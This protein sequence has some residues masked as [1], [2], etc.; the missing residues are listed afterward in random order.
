MTVDQLP[1]P[2]REFASYLDALLARLDPRGGWSGVFW[3]RDAE[4][5][6][7]CLDG[8][9]VPPWD[10]VEA[11]L[12]D[13]GVAYGPAA[14]AAERERARALHAAALTA[15][16]AR[17]GARDAL[18]DRLDVMLRE[19]R[20]AAERQA[21]LT[22]LLSAPVSAEEAESLHRDLAW[23]HDDHARATARCTELRTRIEN[24]DR[25]RG[26]WGGAG[27]GG[28]AWGERRTSDGGPAGWR[29]SAGGV[30]GEGG[31]FVGG[32]VPAEGGGFV[33]GG[34]PAD[35]G[36]LVRGHAR[37]EGGGLVG[38]GVPAEGGAF[39][40]GDASVEGARAAG[41]ARAAQGDPAMRGA[42]QGDPAMRGAR[43][44]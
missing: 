40:G 44:G 25:R 5:M 33:G 10:V 34:V 19:Q 17:P 15:Y 24:L 8:R 37:A 13:L 20:Y 30:P 42:A 27:G 16:D 9:E 12:E 38:G 35:G 26:P 3:Q 6:R 43:S 14:A 7:A 32:G 29:T 41:S 39:D 11:L 31:G 2:V 4:G 18:A 36:G 23:A 22:R 28:G 1:G 21:E